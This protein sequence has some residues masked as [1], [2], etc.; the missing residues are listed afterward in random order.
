MPR[1]LHRLTT[2]IPQT[3]NVPSVRR[4][5]AITFDLLLFIDRPDQDVKV[6]RVS[7][8][9]GRLEDSESRQVKLSANWVNFADIPLC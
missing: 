4:F 9:G 3:C 2:G 6:F 1:I 7:S 8:R 5:V